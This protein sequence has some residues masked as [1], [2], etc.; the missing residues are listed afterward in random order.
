LLNHQ[1]PAGCDSLAVAEAYVGCKFWGFDRHFE[2]L[3]D[4]VRKMFLLISCG[5]FVRVAGRVGEVANC[6]F[7]H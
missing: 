3:M 2:K 4:L 6:F 1:V 7:D 5:R